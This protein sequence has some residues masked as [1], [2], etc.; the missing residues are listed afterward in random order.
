MHCYTK[1]TAQP[2]IYNG[3]EATATMFAYFSNEGHNLNDVLK[4]INATAAE[5]DCWFRLHC[6][7]DFVGNFAQSN[8]AA[9]LEDACKQW[10]EIDRIAVRIGGESWA[11]SRPKFVHELESRIGHL[12]IEDAAEAS[13]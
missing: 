9:A 8:P 12:T 1:T 6:R 7:E 5:V 11:Y 2:I 3:E 10:P 13:Q 4:S